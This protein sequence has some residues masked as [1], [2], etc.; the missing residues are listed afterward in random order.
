M[1]LKNTRFSYT[2][3]PRG[4]QGDVPKVRVDIKKIRRLGWSATLKSEQAI[5]KSIKDLLLERKIHNA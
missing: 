3:G 5:K 4:W 1:G 2:G